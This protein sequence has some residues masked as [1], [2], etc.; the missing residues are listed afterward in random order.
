MIIWVVKTKNVI[1][2]KKIMMKKR[3][4]VIKMVN[5]TTKKRSVVIKMVNT[6]KKNNMDTGVCVAEEE[7]W[8]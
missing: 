1:K 2:I 6:T 7:E 4:V 5:T 8:L 3:S